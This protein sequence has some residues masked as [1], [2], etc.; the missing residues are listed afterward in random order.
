MIVKIGLLGGPNNTDIVETHWFHSAHNLIVWAASPEEMQVAQATPAINI[1][2]PLKMK[3]HHKDALNRW[4]THDWNARL[5]TLPPHLN[6]FVQMSDG[7]DGA[8]ILVPT[9]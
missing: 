3:T 8:S 7:K 5:A 1:M 9:V 6:P 2:S 4:A